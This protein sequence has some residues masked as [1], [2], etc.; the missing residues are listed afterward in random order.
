MTA[1]AFGSVHVI[2][3]YLLVPAVAIFAFSTMISW[4]YYGERCTEYLFGKA[5]ILPYRILYTLLVI[6]GPVMSLG[7]ILDFSDMMLLS[8]AFP[9][10]IG[11]IILAPAVLPLVKD[12][13]QRL[14]SGEMQEYN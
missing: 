6:L 2:F 10:I 11:S 13:V 5:G 8:M 14:K 1:N 7:S 9:N 4:S 12:Y 3:K